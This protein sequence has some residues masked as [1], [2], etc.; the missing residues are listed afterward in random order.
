MLRRR[1]RA[2]PAWEQR[3]IVPAAP[4]V[5]GRTD[6][7]SR[8]PSRRWPT[9]PSSR[10]R[11]R[12]ATSRS[13]CS[14]CRESPSTGSATT[15]PRCPPG[16]TSSPTKRWLPWSITSG[17]AGATT[18]RPSRLRRAAGSAGRAD[19]R[20]RTTRCWSGIWSG[21]VAASSPRASRAASPGTRYQLYWT[22]YVSV[23]VPPAGTSTRHSTRWLSSSR[24]ST[25]SP[26]TRSSWISQLAARYSASRTRIVTAC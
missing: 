19:T 26:S 22:R 11:I 25:G 24:C 6:R 2:E 8:G 7:A 20:T 3:C 15:T 13:S 12:P 21:M 23:R 18:P 5:T 4:A 17:R 1:A 9:T 10:T 16:R 14:A